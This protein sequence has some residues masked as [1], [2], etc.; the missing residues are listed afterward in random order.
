M[1]SSHL[2][3]RLRR[4][5]QSP[6]MASENDWERRRRFLA[7][8]TQLRLL[9]ECLAGRPLLAVPTTSRSQTP[10]TLPAKSP[11][12]G[13]TREPS[14]RQGKTGKRLTPQQPVDTGAS[15]EAPVAEPTMLEQGA[16]GKPNPTTP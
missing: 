5:R 10:F 11:G 13:Q 15:Q 4:P 7:M 6:G 16:G 9:C 1:A 12:Q 8:R 2:S 14:R 3:G